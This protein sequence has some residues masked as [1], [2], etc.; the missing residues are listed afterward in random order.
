MCFKSVCW[1]ITSKCNEHCLFCYRDTSSKDASL[2]KNKIIMNNLISNGVGKIS[3]VGGEPLLYSSLF[4][5]VKYGKSLSNSVQFSI[6]TNATLLT[7][8]DNNGCHVK[9]EYFKQ[10]LSLFDW[11]TFSVDAQNKNTQA[12]LGRNPDHLTR[13]ST[14]IEY[15]RNNDIKIKIKINTVVNKININQI[16]KMIPVFEEYKIDRWKLF[17][18]LPSRGSA[19]LNKELFVISQTEYESCIKSIKQKTWL[20]I[21]SNDILDFKNTYIT[22]NSEGFLSVYNGVTY[23]L[24]FDMS[25]N[26]YSKVFNF[27]NKELHSTR[28]YNYNIGD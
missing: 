6:T 12:E 26:D 23:D 15:I 18:F 8:I 4:E 1:D 9:E 24:P 3:F 2:E 25:I 17:M 10:V 21:T 16:D 19:L 27:I 28:R 20:N 7:Y 22:I 13:V 11:I 14:L 5:L